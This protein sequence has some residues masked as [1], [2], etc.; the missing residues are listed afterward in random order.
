[1]IVDDDEAW[2]NRLEKTRKAGGSMRFLVATRQDLAALYGENDSQRTNEKQKEATGTSKEGAQKNFSYVELV[3]VDADDPPPEDAQRYYLMEPV[4]YEAPHAAAGDAAQ[5]EAEAGLM[6]CID[7]ICL[8]VGIPMHIQGAR[9]I[10][11]AVRIVV[12][13]PEAINRITRTL[14]PCIASRYDTTASKVERS[15]RHAVSVIWKRGRMEPI[16]DLFGFSVCLPD[17]RP[18]NGEFIALLA[19]RCRA[20]LGR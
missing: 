16:N 5:A 6:R 19:N 11:E 3:L 14:Y 10:R 18:T 17:Q 12:D 20:E 4:E 15:I 9:Y 1:M 13:Q 8:R 7:G 2:R